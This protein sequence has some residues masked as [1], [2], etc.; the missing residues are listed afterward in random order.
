[1][2]YTQFESFVGALNRVSAELDGADRENANNRS[3]DFR[4]LKL[5]EI[6]A[7][8]ASF[9]RALFFENIDDLDSRITM[10][11]LSFMRLERDFGTFDEWQKDFIAC[12]MSS[13]DG[14]AVTA[15]SVFLKRYMNFFVDNE[16]KNIPVGALPVIVL[17]VDASTYTR[18]YLDNRHAYVMAMMKELNW[19][20][21]ESRFKRSERVA[22]IAT[23]K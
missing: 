9:L 21:I 17:E 10:D 12:C 23:E 22:K 4:S 7:M 3:S 16:A 6:Y 15:Y 2:L 5:D 19:E 1:M 8:N 14:Y 20:K 18:D 13:R 11:T